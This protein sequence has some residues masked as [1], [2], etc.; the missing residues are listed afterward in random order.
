MS[1]VVITFLTG[2]I[3][4][5]PALTAIQLLWINMIMNSFAAIAL[6]TETPT[7]EV[8]NRYPEAKNGS[9]IT[10]N[11]RKMILFQAIYQIV[12]CCTLSFAGPLLF[13][14]KQASEMTKEDDFELNGLVFN[15][16]VFLQL[17]NEV[18]CRRLDNKLNIFYNLQ[19]NYTF[20]LVISFTVIMQ[21]VIMQVGGNVF[22]TAPIGGNYWA[23]SIVLGCM[24]L[25][26]GISS[27]LVP[28]QVFCCA[29][30][31]AEFAQKREIEINN[32]IELAEISQ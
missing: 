30:N 22:K 1:A 7:V 13:F 8:L 18:N 5:A 16:Y 9:L 12:V 14:D 25:L 32:G 31:E 24:G 15:T 17:F 4:R 10:F 20:M 21:I 3:G 11:M 6:A 28:D 23:L 27:R 2:I 29:N 19:R 26:I